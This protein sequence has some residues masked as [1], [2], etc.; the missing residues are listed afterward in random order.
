MLET[1]RNRTH[2]HIQFLLRMTGTMTSQNNDLSS[3]DKLYGVGWWLENNDLEG[4]RQEA[5]VS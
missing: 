4:I 2:V 3:W 1:V 5:T